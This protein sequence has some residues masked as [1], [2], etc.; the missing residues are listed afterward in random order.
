MEDQGWLLQEIVQKVTEAVPQHS[1][2][3]SGPAISQKH[4]D[5]R[6]RCTDCTSRK[7]LIRDHVGLQLMRKHRR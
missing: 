4:W 5:Q 7:T 1:G 3:D 2:V 6:Q